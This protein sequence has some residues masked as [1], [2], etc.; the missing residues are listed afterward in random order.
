VAVSNPPDPARSA[1]AAEFIELMAALRLWAGQPS[2]RT[3]HRLG[4][5]TTSPTGAR[6]DALPTTTISWVL[7]GKGL[8]RLPRMEFGEAYI[9][10][11][12]AACQ[13]PDH[14]IRAQVGRWRAAWRM[15]ADQPGTEPAPA[16]RQLPMDID[17]FTG[18]HGE[19]AALG[20]YADQTA[21]CPAVVVIEG[22][23]GVGKT[24]LAIHAAHRLVAAGR[25][26][27]AQ[28]W[29]DLRGFH[30]EQPPTDPAVILE[31][32]LRLLGIA[33][34]HVP[35]DID[36]RAA[37]YRDRLSERRA[38]IVLDDCRSEDQVRPLLPGAPG[39]LVLVTSRRTLTGLDGVHSV[40]VGPFSGTEALCLLERYAGRDRVSAEPVAAQ[41]LIDMCGNLPLAVA[42]SAR[43]LR[44]RPLWRLD[45]LVGRLATDERDLSS[46]SPPARAA[47]KVIDLSYRGLSPV[48]QR[49]LRLLAGHPGR[50]VTASSLAALAD[51]PVPETH[52]ALDDLLDEHLVLPVAAHRYGLHDLVRHY[53]TEQSH[54]LDP[55]PERQAGLD[56]LTRHYLTLAR[57]ATHL[58]HPTET[59][60]IPEMSDEQAPWR[61]PADGVNWAE[62]E[63]ESLVATVDQAA[64]GRSPRLALELVA[65][66]YR[67]LANRGHSTDR[68]KLNQLAVRLARRLGDKRAEAQALEDLG[69]ICGQV[70]FTTDA[71]AR[72]RAA[73]ALWTE[74]GDSTGRQGCLADLGNACRQRG[75]HRAAIEYLERS[76]AIGVESGNRHGEGSVLSF[77]GQTHQ[78]AGDIDAAIDC[79]ARSATAYRAAGNELGEAIALANSGWALHETGQPHEAMAYHERSMVVFDRLGDVY[80]AAEQHWGIAQCWHDVGDHAKARHHWDTA[81]TML[82]GIQA[83]D[84]QQVADLLAADVPDTPEI[85]RLNT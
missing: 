23:A 62:Q 39:S 71:L 16:L 28:L 82:H 79:L 45:D 18:R 47:A 8:P 32:F 84:E 63:Y 9:S 14:E 22:M 85:V 10:A 57:Q 1:T 54:R 44:A 5:A 53:A 81:I 49:V 66:L 65:A 25:F 70:G 52:A 40:P 30:P 24:R 68:I 3:L 6:T 7:N 74:L 69:T 51:L 75:E 15:I 41:R 67:P 56:R 33:A 73:L 37:L 50:D 58:I 19:L 35:A 2:L 48:C 76:L 38:L 43:H 42:V 12:L 21:A 83:L 72:S 78:R 29:A 36:G 26:G 4:G 11:C 61:T 46:L 20:E 55:E 17:E 27:D 31:N 64:V 80:D 77:L 34:H 59:R 13:Q 60:R